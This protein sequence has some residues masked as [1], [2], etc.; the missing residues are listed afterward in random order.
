M[1]EVDS[2]EEEWLLTVD[3]DD[4][5]WSKEPVPDSQEDLCIHDI[6]RP[7]TPSPQPNQ[8]VPSTPPLQHNQGLPA[9]PAPHP[10]QIE[11]PPDHEVMELNIPGDVPDLI[12]VPKEVISD[13][14]TWVQT[15]LV[16]A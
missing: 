1:P 10:D 15:V 9:T 4:P 13:F 14:D 7:A 6:P 16:Y 2:D 11:M 5:V 8:R 3:L 12:N